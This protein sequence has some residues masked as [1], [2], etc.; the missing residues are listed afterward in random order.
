MV[1]QLYSII[2]NIQKASDMIDRVIPIPYLPGEK[3]ITGVMYSKLIK[4]C[5]RII[6]WTSRH[7]SGPQKKP[8][9]TMS[10]PQ[11]TMSGPQKTM[12]G[13]TTRYK[14]QMKFTNDTLDEVNRM[15]DDM[16][17]KFNQKID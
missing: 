1:I 5:L 3:Y 17:T 12:N 7:M 11:K 4:L 14:E 9:K 6:I 2:S 16:G 10:G 13:L 8:Q 15:I